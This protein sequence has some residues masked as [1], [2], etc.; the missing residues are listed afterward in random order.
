MSIE[1]QNISFGQISIFIMMTPTFIN[2]KIAT[3]FFGNQ[4]NF[5]FILVVLFGILKAFLAI[6]GAFFITNYPFPSL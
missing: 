3:P 6:L 4:K 1:H 2:L 5:I